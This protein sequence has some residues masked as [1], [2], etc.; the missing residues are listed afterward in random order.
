MSLALIDFHA[1]GSKQAVPEVFD[2]SLDMFKDASV[3][4]RET[5]LGTPWDHDDSRRHWRG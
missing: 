5:S 2:V 3:T 1:V 4:P